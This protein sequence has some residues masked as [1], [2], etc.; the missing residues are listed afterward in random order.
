MGRQD[1]GRRAK[2]WEGGGWPELGEHRDGP[3]IA[4]LHLFSQVA[5]KIATAALPWRNHGWHLTLHVTPRGL[6]TEPIHCNGY[7]FELAFDLIDHRFVFAGGDGATGTVPLRPMSVA[8]FHAET[9]A[10]MAAAGQSVAIHPF[11]NELDPVVALASDDAVRAYDEDSAQR[12]LAALR[13][14]DRVLRLFRSSFIGKA[15]PVHFFWGSFDLA[16]TRFSGRP[17][18]LHPGGIPALPDTVTREAYSHEVSSAGFWPGG[19]NGGAPIF[20]AY[21]YP[22][23]EGFAEAKVEPEAARY[24]TTLGEF[25]LDYDV[26]RTAADPDRIL[27][28]FLESSYAAAADLG[29]WDRASLDCSLGVPGVPRAV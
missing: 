28:G 4:A 7:M 3:T 14:A 13:H 25:V 6:R 22:V 8:T 11:S 16:V 9:M 27:L 2:R 18:P 21:A 29:G 10:M 23:P 24:D 1:I 20:Y 26:V 5:G 19:A 17:A 15:S 12:L